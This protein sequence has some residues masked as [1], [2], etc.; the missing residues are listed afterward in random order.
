MS[1]TDSREQTAAD[2]ALALAFAA[3]IR[4]AG[5]FSAD[6]TVMKE[7]GANLAAQLRARLEREG[8]VRIGAHSHCVF[9]GPIRVRSSIQTYGRFAGLVKTLEDKEINVITF[10]PEVT[11]AELASLAAVLAGGHGRGPDEVNDLLRR[12]GV[13]HVDVEYLGAGSGVQAVAPVE[14]FGAALQLGERLRE[15]SNSKHVDLRQVRHVTQL[16]VDQIMEDPAS[17][18]ALTT[19]KETDDRLISH[20]AN[21][22]ILSVLVGERMGLNK[23]KLGELCLAGFLHDAGKLEVQPEVLGKPGPLDPSEWEEMRRHPVV[24]ARAL[25][26]GPQLTPATMRAVVVAYEHH[27]N[28][29]MTG[30]PP[31]ELRDHVSLFGDIVAVAD[32]YDALT[33]ARTYRRFSFS[34]HEVIS[35]LLY[36][37]GTLFDPMVV[38]L[39][40]GLMGVFPPGTLLRLDNGELAVVCE[41]PAPEGPVDLPRVRMWTGPRTGE[42]VD[43]GPQPD[44]TMLG[45]SVVLSPDGM[46]QV[47]A[48]ELSMFNLIREAETPPAERAPQDV[49]RVQPLLPDDPQMFA[50]AGAWEP[51]AP[52]ETPPADTPPADTPPAD[53]PPV[54]APPA[55][56]PRTPPPANP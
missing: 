21:V 41:P 46:G 15:S 47:P 12:A 5:Y 56:A 2:K 8:F 33:T 27:L 11:Q 32:R 30:Y 10:H 43:T 1:D 28:Y 26:G 6:N 34:P 23:S 55:S 42:V 37:A 53:T 19:I 13:M 54:E 50:A 14:A 9:I 49:P 25:L 17:L 29:D 4:T 38:K 16:V 51:Q 35:Y 18:V 39:F 31:S 20:S 52:V 22:A 3:A 40:V 44:G 48:M 36:Y 7:I 45:V 24:A